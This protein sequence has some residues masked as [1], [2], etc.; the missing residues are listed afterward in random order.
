MAA[1]EDPEIGSI[2]GRIETWDE[3]GKQ[4]W[5]IAR[6]YQGQLN[7]NQLQFQNP[8]QVNNNLGQYN[9]QNLSGG[10]TYP[11]QNSGPSY[12]MNQNYGQNNQ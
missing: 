3:C 11:N 12:G 1:K 10:N 7:S 2:F 6:K 4:L 9:H 5:R 8:V